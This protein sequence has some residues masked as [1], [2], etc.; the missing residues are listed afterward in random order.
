M[1]GSAERRSPSETIL[2]RSPLARRSY[3]EVDLT[4]GTLYPRALTCSSTTQ[5]YTLCSHRTHGRKQPR[6]YTE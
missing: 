1:S 5:A 6:P 3:S 2:F 4:T